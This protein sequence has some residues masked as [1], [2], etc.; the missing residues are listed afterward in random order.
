MQQRHDPWKHATANGWVDNPIA[1]RVDRAGPQTVSEDHRPGLVPPD[2][3]WLINSLAV[4]NVTGQA[5]AVIVRH[6]RAILYLL[7]A[8]RYRGRGAVK[9]AGSGKAGFEVT[10]RTT[11]AEGLAKQLARLERAARSG[12]LARWLKA[13]GATSLE[14][15]R[16][17]WAP[18]LVNDLPRRN[19]AGHRLAD[20]RAPVGVG[21]H[22]IGPRPADALPVIVQARK[23]LAAKPLNAR[24]G[25][26]L[27]REA[28][29]LANVI[30]AAVLELAGR[31]GITFNPVTGKATG[32]LVEFGAAFDERFGTQINWRTI[33]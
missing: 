15:R 20:R 19:I 2:V 10:G 11:A 5:D 17:I 16:L 24:R 12:S 18:A 26:R 1:A 27:N 29:E 3:D 30:K 32:P 8:L 6:A 14:A 9:V 31:I 33:G 4:L 28:D 23:E 22:F 21:G 13:W 7:T 25:N